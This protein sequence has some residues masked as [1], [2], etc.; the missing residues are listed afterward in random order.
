MKVKLVVAVIVFAISMFCGLVIVTNGILAGRFNSMYPYT[1]QDVCGDDE[2][3]VLETDTDTSSGTVVIDN[4]LYSDVGFTANTL[5]CVNANGEKRDV[6]DETY[7]AFEKLK[8]RIGWWSTFGFFLVT[9]I[10]I[11]VFERPIIR[12]IDKTIGYK[13]P[14]EK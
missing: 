6:T 9:M 7:D 2:K 3:L 10:L 13:P 8:T 5:Y 11:L 12:R 4:I 14:D 1:A